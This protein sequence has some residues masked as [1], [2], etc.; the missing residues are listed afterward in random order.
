[1]KAGARIKTERHILRH[2]RDD[3]LE[4]FCQLN[5]KGRVTRFFVSRHTHEHLKRHVPYL[6]T[7][8]EW[9]ARQTLA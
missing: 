1:V 4:E 8:E 7:R 6:T 2:W 3:D 5:N 9:Q